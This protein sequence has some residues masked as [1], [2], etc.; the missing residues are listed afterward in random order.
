MALF[1]RRLVRFLWFWEPICGE[2]VPARVVALYEP[3]FLLVTP[4]LD[5]FLS[6]DGEADVAE[7]FEMHEAGDSIAVGESGDESEAM[8]G[9][10]ALKV[11]R[12]AGIEVS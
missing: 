8:L 6:R 9:H 4:S 2:I 10:A 7:H 3:D 1:L 12:D 5:F 11:V